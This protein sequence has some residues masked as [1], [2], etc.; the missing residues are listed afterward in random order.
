MA[1]ISF[2]NF[3]KQMP[4]TTSVAACSGVLLFLFELSSI[5]G[6][7]SSW[8]S[9]PGEL[10]KFPGQLMPR[11]KVKR[12]T[13]SEREAAVRQSLRKVSNSFLLHFAHVI[14]SDISRTSLLMKSRAKRRKMKKALRKIRLSNV[15]DPRRNRTRIL[16]KRSQ[17]R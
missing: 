6:S 10:Y 2:A 14:M 16:I 7:F 8:D 3:P 1:P 4:A 17:K 5:L 11:V 13:K 12:L 15:Q 9:I